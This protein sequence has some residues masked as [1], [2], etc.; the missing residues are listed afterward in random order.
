MSLPGMSAAV[1]VMVPA[2]SPAAFSSGFGV[3]VLLISASVIGVAA[4]AGAAGGAC[5]AGVCA[6]TV[7]RS[8]IDQTIAQANNTFF[9]F[10]ILSISMFLMWMAVCLL[11]PV[12]VL[13][14]GR[15]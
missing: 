7:P 14:I 8:P 4:A 12:G 6:S 5:A 15:V 2:G 9:M 13:L 3:G 10:V 1:P 11:I